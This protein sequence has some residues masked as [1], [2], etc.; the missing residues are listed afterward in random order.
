MYRASL[1]RQPASSIGERMRYGFGFPK[2]TPSQ[3]VVV[4][5]APSVTIGTIANGFGYAPAWNV[6]AD[7]GYARGAGDGVSDLLDMSGNARH[8]SQPVE[9]SQPLW[10]PTDI[11]GLPAIAGDGIDDCLINTF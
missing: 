1:R 7:W 10:L 8:F 3:G 6:R 11:N 4:V 5:P 9:G 2:G